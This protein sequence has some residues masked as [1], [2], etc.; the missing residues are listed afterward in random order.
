MRANA[1]WDWFAPCTSPCASTDV[2]DADSE[3]NPADPDRAAYS[4]RSPAC[5]ELWVP[6]PLQ[7]GEGSA[8]CG[9][10]PDAPTAN[11]CQS[12]CRWIFTGAGCRGAGSVSAVIKGGKVIVRGGGGNVTPDG[13]SIRSAPATDLRSPPRAVCREIRAPGP[14]IDPTAVQAP[15]SKVR[16]R[17][18]C[19]IMRT[20]ESEL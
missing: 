19:D 8:A 13:T 1:C 4:A 6:C 18:C 9:R 10:N 20:S 11:G 5:R 12:V 14:T 16:I 7:F 2:H 3:Q 15:G 17:G